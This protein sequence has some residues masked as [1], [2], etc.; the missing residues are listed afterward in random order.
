MDPVSSLTQQRIEVNES[1]DAC[2]PKY[3]DD[4]LQMYVDA[5]CFVMPSYREGFPNTVME[6]AQWVC[7]LL[8]LLL[9]VVVR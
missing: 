1:I 8:L 6:V 4:L 7:H 2:G 9:M 5:D 3:G